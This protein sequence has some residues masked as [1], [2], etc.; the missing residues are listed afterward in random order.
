MSVNV[1]YAMGILAGLLP[2]ILAT[3]AVADGGIPWA[4]VMNLQERSLEQQCLLVDLLRS[5]PLLSPDRAW[6]VY[7]RLMVQVDP[8]GEADGL[9]SVVFAQH[10]PSGHLQV[11]Y[12]SAVAGVGAELDFSVLLPYAWQ[13]E[14][15]LIR[16]R[17]GIFQSDV[18]GDRAVVWSAPSDPQATLVASTGYYPTTNQTSIEIWQPLEPS[19]IIEVLGWDPQIPQRVLFAVGEMGEEPE[20]RSL[21]RA[22]RWIP[23]DLDVGLLSGSFNP[24][25]LFQSPLLAQGPDWEAVLPLGST[26]RDPS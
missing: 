9:S 2:G 13:G 5:Q 12:A 16:E 25:P 14:T 21:G 4:W 24:D 8:Q 6:Q 23:R 7:S 19:S 10:R 3:S 26:C 20:V 11:V 17:E 18:M 22:G 1:K 15:L